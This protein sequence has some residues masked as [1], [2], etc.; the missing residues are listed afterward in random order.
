MNKFSTGGCDPERDGKGQSGQQG[1][2][3]T[4]SLTDTEFEKV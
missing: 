2:L 1:N 3:D 4:T